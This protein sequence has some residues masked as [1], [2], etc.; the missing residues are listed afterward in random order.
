[1]RQSRSLRKRAVRAV[2]TGREEPLVSRERRNGRTVRVK[3]E[4]RFRMLK[5][6]RRSPTES[7]LLFEIDSQPL[8]EV[9]T[10]LGGMPLVLQTFRSLSL[11]DSVRRN[12]RTKERQRGL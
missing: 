6:E 5:R 12:V 4:V 11:P 8:E 1:M 3:D 7:P 2:K 10:G 9:L